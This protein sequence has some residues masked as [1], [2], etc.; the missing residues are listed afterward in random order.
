MLEK[1]MKKNIYLITNADD[2]GIS[3]SVTDAIIECHENGFLTSTTLMANMSGTDYAI[4]M[5]KKYPKLGIGIH[6]NLTEGSPLTEHQKIPLILNEKG[7]F[8]S[9][10]EQ[11]KNLIYGRTKQKQV[12]SELTSQIEYLL[13]NGVELTHFDSHH[14]ITGTPLA[15]NASSTVAKRFGLRKARS[16]NINYRFTEDYQKGLALRLKKFSKRC[17]SQLYT[18]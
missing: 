12:E 5:Q 9:N 18:R 2:F 7:E 4:K 6:F 13:D 14:H 8:K 16:T 11:R 17:P 15:F 10:L 1:K 3:K